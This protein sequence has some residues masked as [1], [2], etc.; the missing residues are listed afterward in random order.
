MK[1]RR[2]P[3]DWEKKLGKRVGTGT[4]SQ[5]APP[6]VPPPLHP[7]R[8]PPP[9]GPALVFSPGQISQKG[10]REGS[11]ATKRQAWDSLS[12]VPSVGAL[13]CHRLPLL[14]T[15]SGLFTDRRE[16]IAVPPPTCS[17][18]DSTELTGLGLLV[19]APAGDSLRCPGRAPADAAAPQSP[20][21]PRPP[22]SAPR[23]PPN[24]HTVAG[25]PSSLISVGH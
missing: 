2:D 13:F 9:T 25:C 19:A 8:P 21:R 7:H 22:N 15:V 6:G 16:F 18:L 17:A 1:V 23:P 11:T 14:T 12:I 4:R 3:Q 24:T 5:H 10:P 20:T